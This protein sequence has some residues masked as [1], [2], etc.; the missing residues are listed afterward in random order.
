MNIDIPA[1]FSMENAQR[2]FPGTDVSWRFANA[3]KNHA[4]PSECIACGACEEACPQHIEIR[5][6]LREIAEKNEK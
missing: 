1:L 6:L 2:E 5:D 3:T 4:K